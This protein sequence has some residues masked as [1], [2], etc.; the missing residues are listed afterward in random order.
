MRSSVVNVF[1]RQ[2]LRVACCALVAMRPAA[3]VAQVSVGGG[4]R[5]DRP[6][7]SVK[8]LRDRH[9]V[10]QRLDFSCGAAAL[11]TL[12][13][14]GFGANISERLILDD[15][16]KLLSEEEK[17]AV[18]ETGFSLLHLQRVAQAR[19]YNAE[20]FRL[21]PDDLSMLAGPVIVFIEPRG[22]QH[23]AVLRGVDGDRVYLADPA[24]GNIRVPRYAFL[25][26]WLQDDEKG[27]IFVVEP[28]NGL[29]NTRTPLALEQQ[30]RPF[31][32]LMTARE[33]MA[34]GSFLIR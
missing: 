1:Y 32:E 13:R 2:C 15:L 9:V 31:A 14:F 19:G 33:M 7:V 25:R 34:I 23:F 8:D 10:K 21:A 11:A 29:P 17:S 16:Y 20:G 3:T 6:A 26:D 12:M 30:D 22:Y 4:L 28:Q 5:V 24:R 18:R 27:I